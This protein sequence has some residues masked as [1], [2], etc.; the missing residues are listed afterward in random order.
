LL[1][2]SCGGLT[3]GVAVVVSPCCNLIC[4]HRVGTE[5][6]ATDDRGVIA[7]LMVCASDDRIVRELLSRDNNSINMIRVHAE[8]GVKGAIVSEALRIADVFDDLPTVET[9]RL[10]LREVCMGDAADLF[11]YASD[12][13]VARYTTWEPHGSIDESRRYLQSAV[14]AQIDGDVRTW[15]IVH[16]GDN[17]F[18]GTAGFLFWDLT[19]QR[20]EIGYSLSRDY[21]AQ[22]LM[23]EAVLSIVR[24]GF[25]HMRLN[26]IE[27]RCDALN[28]GSTRVLEKAGMIHEG[29]L[30]EQFV[31][32][33]EYRDL[34]L[35]AILRQ[36]WTGG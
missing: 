2:T 9:K 35:Y 26:R 33:G 21:W 22:G 12:S 8:T 3:L 7:L 16:K 32:D 23:T 20:S 17:R 15:G 1:L 10:L 6:A 25:E 11:R 31:I 36:G 27:A 34:K 29:T 30:R 28:T 19:A 24:F 18:I 14:D 13:E 4:Q 5:I